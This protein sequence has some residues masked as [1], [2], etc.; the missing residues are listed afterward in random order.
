MNEQQFMCL[1]S[2]FPRSL[3]CS[4]VDTRAVWAMGYKVLITY[5]RPWESGG[6]LKAAGF[7][8]DLRKTIILNE[9]DT[10][11]GGLVCWIR[12]VHRPATPADMAET[13]RILARTHHVLKQNGVSCHD[14]AL[15]EGVRGHMAPPSRP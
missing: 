4:R 10:I 13:N 8:I 14:R 5:T 12:D 15:P 1:R 7:Y 2:W 6:S 11:D 9:D 3:S